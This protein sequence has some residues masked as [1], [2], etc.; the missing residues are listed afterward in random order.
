[1][2]LCKY[3]FV[4]ILAPGEFLVW[5]RVTRFVGEGNYESN[6]LWALGIRMTS[7]TPFPFTASSLDTLAETG[8]FHLNVFSLRLRHVVIAC[9]ASKRIRWEAAGP[10]KVPAGCSRE[11]SGRPAGNSFDMGNLPTSRGVVVVKH[12]AKVYLRRTVW[13]TNLGTIGASSEQQKQQLMWLK[14]SCISIGSVSKTWGS[15]ILSDIGCGKSKVVSTR[16]GRM[17]CDSGGRYKK[18]YGFCRNWFGLDVFDA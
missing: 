14:V 16:H 11:S 9:R 6:T 1:M 13:R 5:T 17:G 3:S 4:E 2:L 7:F 12:C 15:S 18:G 8:S 10:S